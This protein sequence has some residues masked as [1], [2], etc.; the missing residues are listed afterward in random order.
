[1]L[2]RSL[3]AALLIWSNTPTLSTLE[4][5]TIEIMRIAMGRKATALFEDILIEQTPSDGF[6]GDAEGIETNPRGFG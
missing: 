5:W 4:D 3:R 6:F 2:T 1:M